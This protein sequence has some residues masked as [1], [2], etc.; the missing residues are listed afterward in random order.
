MT[1]ALKYGSIES[2]EVI[3]LPHLLKPIFS[4]NFLRILDGDVEGSEPNN[5]V[6][7][8]RIGEEFKNWEKMI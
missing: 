6:D 8:E 5:V 1:K 3:Y 7:F 4:E 2:I